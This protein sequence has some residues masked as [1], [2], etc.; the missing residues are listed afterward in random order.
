MFCSKCGI[1][2]DNDSKFCSSC[3]TAITLDTQSVEAEQLTSNPSITNK[4]KKKL[5][6]LALTGIAILLLIIFLIYHTKTQ[7][8]VKQT[9]DE[10]NA[11]N[12]HVVTGQ[13][14]IVGENVY[15]GEKKVDKTQSN[16]SDVD[17]KK[18]IEKFYQTG[19]AWT[20][21][22]TVLAFNSCSE[23]INKSTEDGMTFE[24]HSPSTYVFRLRVGREG[25][26]WLNQN[27]DPTIADINRQLDATGT[28][29]KAVSQINGNE[30]VENLT[31]PDG[32]IVVKKY[33]YLSNEDVLELYD[34]D[35]ADCEKHLVCRKLKEGITSRMKYCKGD[36]Q[37]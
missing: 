5:A 7:A 28:T 18:T 12:N 27:N 26:N 35:V 32:S 23:I 9:E 30:I 36:Y 2:I 24:N 29:I 13:N 8:L 31:R 14:V 34:M 20:D 33:R 22:K 37:N 10:I 4:S 17:T 25:K 6:I 15:I 1:A 11:E 21:E 19:G 3:G 16:Q